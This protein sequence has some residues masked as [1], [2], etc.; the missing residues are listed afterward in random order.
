MKECQELTSGRAHVAV[1]WGTR[2]FARSEAWARHHLS[3]TMGS[4]L[5]FS[6]P[7]FDNSIP[8]DSKTNDLHLP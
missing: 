5:F 1:K 3:K 8:D 4:L 6:S 7:R 2:M